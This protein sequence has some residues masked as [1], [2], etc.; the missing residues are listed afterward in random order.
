MSQSTFSEK[1]EDRG[2]ARARP[3]TC[4]WPRAQGGIG[5]CTGPGRAGNSRSWTAS[6]PLLGASLGK[7]GEPRAGQVG[8]AGGETT[9][10]RQA[11]AR[12]AQ[13]GTRPSASRAPSWAVRAAAPGTSSAF[14]VPSQW[15]PSLTCLAVPMQVAQHRAGSRALP[16]GSIEAVLPSAPAA[17]RCVSGGSSPTVTAGYLGSDCQPR[18]GRSGLGM[19]AVLNILPKAQL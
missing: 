4:S 9:L 15:K 19:H 6:P 14:A 1:S 13:R 5:G 17:Q 3:L 7:P 10:S 16:R 11:R 2:R 18:V 12:G 8:S